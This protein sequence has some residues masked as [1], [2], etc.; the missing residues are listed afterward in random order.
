MTDEKTEAKETCKQ[1]KVNIEIK[2]SRNYN[3]ITL[4][5]QDEPLNSATEDEFR[6]EIKKVAAILREEAEAQIRLLQLK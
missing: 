6:G 5:I 3:T 4:G 2:I 1:T